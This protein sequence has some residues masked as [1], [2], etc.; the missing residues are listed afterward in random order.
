MSAICAGTDHKNRADDWSLVLQSIGISHSVDSVADGWII[1]VDEKSL[2]RARQEIYLYE[3]ENSAWPVRNIHTPPEYGHKPPTVFIML[4]LVLFYSITGDHWAVNMWFE[5]GAVAG[6]A[7]LERGEWWRAVTALTLHNGPVHLL[8]NVIIGGLMTHMLCRL[9]GTGTGWLLIIVAGALGNILNV[10]MRGGDHLSVGFST[11]VFGTIGIL[12][13]LQLRSAVNV[14]SLVVPIGAGLS[15]LA[16]LGS[17]GERTDLG[18]H[19]WG[20]IAGL[21]M[22]LAWTFLPTA[23]RVFM[24]ENLQ[25]PFFMAAVAIIWG[26]WQLAFG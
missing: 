4:V 7:M 13:G 26:G 9:T 5:Q 15:L 10:F 6:E 11:A 19:L 2:E 16:M 1:K 8:S 17:G 3:K 14:K 24:R 18:A 12:C 22:G 25:F 20:L 23:G 21:A